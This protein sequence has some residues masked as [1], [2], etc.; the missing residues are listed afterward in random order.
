MEATGEEYGLCKATIARLIRVDK[1]T[2]DLK[3]WLDNGFLP[4]KAGV[5]LSYIP[6]EAQDIL[7]KFVSESKTAIKLDISKA[8]GIREAFKKYGNVLSP[9]EIIESLFCQKSK[10]AKPK[11][12]TIKPSVY[13][14]YFAD[15]VTTSEVEETIKKA[16]EMYFAVD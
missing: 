11:E 15:G 10:P 16:L 12:V 9:L 5:E 3:L 4:L 8:K 1:L 14:K 2:G 6:Q 7:Y 13:K